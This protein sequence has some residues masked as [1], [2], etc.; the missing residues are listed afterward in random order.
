[1]MTT[2]LFRAVLVISVLLPACPLAAQEDPSDR[3]ALTRI[4]EAY[5]Q[6]VNS[7]DLSKFQPYLAHDFD[8]VIVTG[9]PV[10]SFQ[11]LV[12]YWNKIKDMIGPG[13]KY[14]CKLN[15][16]RTDIFGNI[17]VSRGTTDEYAA[18]ASG[19]EYRFHEQ[20][21]AVCRKE[22]GAW[23]VVRVHGSMDP[24]GN[25][26]VATEKKW[27]RIGFGVGGFA[28]GLVVSLLLAARRRKPAAAV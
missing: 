4:K 28:A 25:I 23:K 10:K 18:T 9:E 20:W 22:N 1:M 3:D 7:G 8:G 12:A 13:G 15:V 26:F 5:E 14:E 17:A 2:R 21:T 6:G 27:I 19:R 24:L 11:D 16:E